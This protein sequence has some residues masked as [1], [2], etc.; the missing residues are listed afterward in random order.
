MLFSFE[1]YYT[2]FKE[3]KILWGLG[4]GGAGAVVR[5]TYMMAGAKINHLLIVESSA[6]KFQNPIII[7]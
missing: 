6:M 2:Q 1:L 3:V 4:G 5:G 7:H